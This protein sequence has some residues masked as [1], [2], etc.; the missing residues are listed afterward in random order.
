MY[1][2][3]FTNCLL[4]ILQEEVRA[5][6]G[7]KIDDPFTRRSTKPRMVFKASEGS[8]DVSSIISSQDSPMTSVRFF[9]IF[10]FVI[11]FL[12]NYIFRKYLNIK[13]FVNGLLNTIEIIL[14]VCDPLLLC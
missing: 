2:Y 8:D 4:Q 11:F 9:I 13:S 10:I 7:K 12:I 14:L 3:L 6:K 5:N 1:F